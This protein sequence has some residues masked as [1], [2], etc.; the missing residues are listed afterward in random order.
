MVYDQLAAYTAVGA[1][2]SVDQ[3]QPTPI[4][5]RYAYASGVSTLP[6][7]SLG[8]LKPV[9]FRI[10]RVKGLAPL[11]VPVAV[12][13]TMGSTPRGDPLWILLDVAFCRITV[14]LRVSRPV[15]P[16]NLVLYLAANTL[17]PPLAILPV[18]VPVIPDP[19]SAVGNPLLACPVVSAPSSALCLTKLLACRSALMGN[20][21]LTARLQRTD[22]REGSIVQGGSLQLRFRPLPEPFQRLPGSLCEP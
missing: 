11:P 14:S 20:K 9:V 2:P 18:L 8:D 17:P 15:S 19:F 3:Q 10:C 4:T 6:R 21:W 16:G 5:Y 13:G 7:T 22:Q 12:R 1:L